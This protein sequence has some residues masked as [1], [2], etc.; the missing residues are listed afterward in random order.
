[1]T[2]VDRVV[3]WSDNDPE[4]CHSSVECAVRTDC[5]SPAGAF[6]EGMMDGS[7]EDDPY[8]REPP[9]EDQIHDLAKMVDEFAHIGEY[10]YPSRMSAVNH[11]EDGVWEVK[12]GRHRLAYFDTPGDGTYEPK[13]MVD[14]YALSGGHDDDCWRYPAMDGVLLLT[15][16]FAKTAQSA[17]Q[18]QVQ[19]ALVIR[20][21]D[22]QH[23]R[24]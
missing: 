1:M 9:D 8:F 20:E 17:P 24:S 16:G 6:V 5:T 4:F 22:V 14:D 3:V 10:G 13:L 23:D 7:Y 18:D 15:N 11:L 21:E 19:L 2:I 12:V